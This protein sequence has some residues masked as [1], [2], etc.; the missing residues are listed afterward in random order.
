[1]KTGELI[2]HKRISLGL[3]AEDVAE[4]IGVSPST[5]YRYESNNISNMG[6]DKL[7]AIADVLHTDAHALLGWNAPAP[8]ASTHTAIRIPVLGSVPAGVPIEAIEDIIDWEDLSPDQFDTDCRYFGLRI[9]GDSM[10]PK[11]LEADT[12]IVRIQS[13]CESGQDAVVYVN[14]YEAT[15]KKVV[16]QEHGVLLQPLNP[17]Y[18][19]MFYSY[20]D[21]QHPVVVAGVVVEIRRKV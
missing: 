11:Y 19:P 10:Y 2:K 20:D 6:I 15:L 8:S 5:I 13:D 7:K 18:D 4:K 12:V 14:G 1:M 17:E 21:V 9:K 3:S 16:K